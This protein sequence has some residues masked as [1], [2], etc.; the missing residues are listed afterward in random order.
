MWTTPTAD[1]TPDVAN[2]AAASRKSAPAVAKPRKAINPLH[3][4]RTHR[5]IAIGVAV[6]AGGLGLPI[7][8]WKGTPVYSSEAVVYVSP[9]F[10][11]TLQD[12]K[13][14]ELQ[15]NTQYREY[16]QQNVR[17]VNR[18]DII[19][20]ALT[21]LGHN[22]GYWQE[23]DETDRRAIERLQA[24]L[25]IRPIPDTYQIV[26]ALE[27]KKPAGL[28]DVVNAVVETYLERAKDEEFYD[29][30][31]TLKTLVDD[32]R[33]LQQ[34]IDLKQQQ[35][36]ALAQEL[37]ISTFT[38]SY[39]NPYDHLAVGGKE[40]LAEASR[41]RIESDSQLDVIDP[42]AGAPSERALQA[43][44]RDSAA[45]DTEIAS[46]LAALNQRRTD[47][48]AK[49][50]GLSPEHPA[51]RG[52][53]RELEEIEQER[54]R[55][56][57]KTVA[58]Y[59][60][61]LLE[62][63]RSEAAKGRRIEAE[64]KAEVDRQSSLASWFTQKYQEAITLGLEIERAR[65]RLGEIADRVDFLELE[66]QAPGFV[67]MFSRARPADQPSQGGRKKLFLVFLG[68]AIVSGLLTPVAID[69]LDP[70]IHTATDAHRVLGFPPLAW[71]PIYDL[72]LDFTHEQLLGLA[73]RMDQ[74][75]LKTGSRIFVFTSVL[76]GGGVTSVVSETA[77][78]LA[79]LG[80]PALAVEANAYRSDH[81]YSRGGGGLS[82]V[83]QGNTDLA[84]VIVPADDEM[85]DHVAVGE[86]GSAR[87]LPDIHRLIE[88]LRM[89]AES[90]PMVLLD[91][92]P[93]V[94]SVDAEYLARTADVVVLVCEAE[95]VK[96]PDLR[97]AVAAL[98]R[99]DPKAVAC[100][101]N[102]VRMD[103]LDGSPRRALAEYTGKPAP[104]STLWSASWL[105]R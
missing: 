27:S 63:R 95:K 17:T 66:T 51:R 40:A 102:K 30:D 78:A 103:G 35:R 104:Q 45:K 26:V 90:Y 4:L 6:V 98:E 91:L 9:H 87:N 64:L 53:N 22:R 71:L 79:A 47:L 84:E 65:K 49:V 57:D 55:L 73:N 21:R 20:E 72:D 48:L 61:L 99:L 42:Q 85:P 74:D 54:K 100:V 83:L 77:R 70:R 60:S 34:E 11:K 5:R 44:A 31:K 25:E 86:T 101:V 28:A 37:G 15:S 69:Y 39:Q 97:R 36:T 62:Q 82:V 18:Y 19:A 50:S 59:A 92:P 16:V 13:E 96:E 81:R 33:R 12:D 3:S 105:W 32:R 2:L 75:R 88:V 52:A 67:R 80:I 41:H 1:D 68:A 56:V 58:F 76:P 14:N 10:V 24:A 43:Y 8:W 29:S 38:E 23:K 93:V 94:L 89:G 46:A 7:A